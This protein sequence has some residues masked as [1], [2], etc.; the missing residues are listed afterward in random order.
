[1][2]RSAMRLRAPGLV[3]TMR[4]LLA[5]PLQQGFADYLWFALIP[6]IATLICLLTAR[7]ATVRILASIF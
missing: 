7:I 2:L 1:M 4:E 5:V 3:S 6:V